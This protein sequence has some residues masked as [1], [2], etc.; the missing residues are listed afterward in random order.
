MNHCGTGVTLDHF[1]PCWIILRVFDSFKVA[2]II[3][4]YQDHQSLMMIIKF[5]LLRLGILVN[6]LQ[7]E[8]FEEQQV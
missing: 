8:P 2:R 5:A 4:P 6:P 7:R 1:E 3:N